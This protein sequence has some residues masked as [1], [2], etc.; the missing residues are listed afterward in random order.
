MEWQHFCI[1][2]SVEA[3]RLKLVHN[4]V[5]EVNYTRSQDIGELEDYIPL[6]WFNPSNLFVMKKHKSSI[7][8]HGSF[9]N[10]N[11]WDFELSDDEMTSF[12]KCAAGK[13]QGNLI[14]WNIGDWNHERYHTVRSTELECLCKS[15]VG[16]SGPRTKEESYNNFFL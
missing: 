13:M 8:A 2:Y 3:K 16:H 7:A 5:L 9:T 15:K 14:S 10:F 1:T 12:T 4:G 11:V 6:S